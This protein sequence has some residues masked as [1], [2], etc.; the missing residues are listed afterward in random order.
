MKCLRLYSPF[1]RLFSLSTLS[2]LASKTYLMG[3]EHFT[4]PPFALVTAVFDLG[5]CECY[6]SQILRRFM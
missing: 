1:N 2:F 4:L 6:L 5:T 3:V